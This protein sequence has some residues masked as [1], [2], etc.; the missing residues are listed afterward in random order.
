MPTIINLHN[1]KTKVFKGRFGG[2]HHSSSPDR[3]FDNSC[4]R[5]AVLRLREREAMQEIGECLY[6]KEVDG[7]FDLHPH[8]LELPDLTLVRQRLEHGDVR[9]GLTTVLHGALGVAQ[10]GPNCIEMPVKTRGRRRNRK[11]LTVI[12]LKVGA[13]GYISAAHCA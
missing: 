10:W 8:D 6:L 5:H 9:G 7:T 1:G 4:K 12:T 2:D 13:D 3:E 11:S